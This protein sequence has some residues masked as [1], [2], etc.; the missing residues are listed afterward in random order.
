MANTEATQTSDLGSAKIGPLIFRL[1]V[2]TIVAQII[3]LLYNIVDRIYIGHIPDTGALELTG[4][5][6]CMPLITLVMAFA[7]LGGAGGSPRASIAMGEKNDKLA[8]KIM[9]NC[10]SLLIILAVITTVIFFVFCEPMLLTFGASENTIEYAVAYMKI[11]SL[12]TIFVMITLGMNYFITAQGFAKT[13]M[14]TTLIGAVLNIVLDPV[15]IFVFGMGCQGAALATIL[16]QAVSMIWVLIFL[17]GKKTTLRI[18]RE[19][20]KIDFSVLGPCLALGL[21]PFVM[22][23]T[24][25]LLSVAFNSSLLQYGGDMAVGAMTILSSVMQFS[26]M[27]LQG[28]TQGAVPVI[29]YNFGARNAERVKKAFSVLLISALVYSMA[30]WLIVMIFPGLFPAMFTNSPDLEAYSSWAIRIYMGASGIFGIQMSCQQTFIGIGNAKT[31]LFLACLRKIILLIP[32][33]YL[34]PNFFADKVF[35]V[36]LAEPVSDVIAVSVTS[37]MFFFQFRKAL[38]KLK[39]DS[40]ALPV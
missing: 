24:E 2:P 12:G 4:V 38:A 25:S 29:S 26:N 23:A 22:C 21:S 6:V 13:A 15:F 36:F 9:G 10:L 27:P 31:S 32:M 33:I 16:S 11:Y 7:M 17:S 40:S 14:L 30:I 1:A 18:R 34:L 37:I 5:G 20:L 35:A 19:N 39:D 28:L 8:E 3:N